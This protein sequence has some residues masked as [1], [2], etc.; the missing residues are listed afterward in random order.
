M[1]VANEISDGGGDACPINTFTVTQ[2]ID[3]Q[4]HIFILIK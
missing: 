4:V 2:S 1:R 3:G